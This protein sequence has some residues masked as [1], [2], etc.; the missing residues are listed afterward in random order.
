M[1]NTAGTYLSEIY[2]K[3]NADKLKLRLIEACFGIQQSVPDQARLTNGE[4]V[5]MH[6][7]KL[8]ESILMLNTML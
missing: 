4:F 1:W 7:S 3:L 8:K 5:L 2:Q 6:V